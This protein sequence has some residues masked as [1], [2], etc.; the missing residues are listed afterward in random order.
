MQ[1]FGIQKTAPEVIILLLYHLPG[2]PI[3]LCFNQSFVVSLMGIWCYCHK[4]ETV[5]IEIKNYSAVVF[6]VLQSNKNEL[7]WYDV[8]LIRNSQ[9]DRQWVLVRLYLMSSEKRRNIIIIILVMAN[10]RL[11][12]W[13]VKHLRQ[14]SRIFFLWFF[15]FFVILEMGWCF[16]LFL[17][18]LT[19]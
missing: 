13:F 17:K 11:L 7:W 14:M 16:I 15:L 5:R 18:I 8:I 19:M 6:V 9:T 10:W 1:N 3:G 12:P 2:C 4:L